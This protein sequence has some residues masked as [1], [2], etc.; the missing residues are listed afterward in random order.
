M[1]FNWWRDHIYNLCVLNSCMF[2]FRS[3]VIERWEILHG[4]K[5]LELHTC[6]P[7]ILHLLPWFVVEHLFV[8]WTSKMQDIRFPTIRRFNP[9]DMIYTDSIWI[10]M[11]QVEAMFFS[12]I[13][14]SMERAFNNKNKKQLE[15]G[16]ISDRIFSWAMKS[17]IFRNFVNNPC[18]FFLWSFCVTR[19]I[20]S[21]SRQAKFLPTVSM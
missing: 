11:M 2:V 14:F 4:W 20:P 12:G 10:V 5:Q 16:T 17:A 1:C 21:G 3:I 6:F 13:T 15:T 8:I 18:V 19:N 9:S 7:L